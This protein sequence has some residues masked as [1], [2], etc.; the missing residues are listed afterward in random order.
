MLRSA[1]KPSELT[2][3]EAF[4]QHVPGKL[5]AGSGGRSWKD[6]LVQLFSRQHEQDTLIVPA[7]PEPLIVWVLSGEAVVEERPLGGAWLANSVKAGDF[8]G[9]CRLLRRNLDDMVKAR[10][11]MAR[12]M[13]GHDQGENVAQ[14]DASVG[15]IRYVLARHCQ[16]R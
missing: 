2:S 14:M 3:A 6:L 16:G 10:G 15:D 11:P 1:M 7:V 4:E 9:L 12:C 8:V 13:T 5:I